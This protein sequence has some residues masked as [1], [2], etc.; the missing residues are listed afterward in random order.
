L[1]DVILL[2]E[3][4]LAYTVLRRDGGQSEAQFDPISGA[5][6]APDILGK[7]LTTKAA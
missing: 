6:I 7:K 4:T 2:A 1:L 3:E 5:S